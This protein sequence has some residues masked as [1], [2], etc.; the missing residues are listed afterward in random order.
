[1][2]APLL[3]AL[4]GP[5]RGWPVTGPT[6]VLRAAL[7]G[8]ALATGAGAQATPAAERALPAPG[9]A[10]WARR[11][12]PDVDRSTAWL[13]LVLDGVRAVRAHS[14]CSASA[15]AF[16]LGEHD[17]RAL[18]VLTWRWKVEWAPVIDDHRIRSGDDFALRV[19]AVFAPGHAAPPELHYV[20]TRR[21]PRGET[22]TSPGAA[23]TRVIS[24]G[25]GTLDA[26]ESVRADLAADFERAFRR[27][28]PALRAIHLL[29]DTDDSCQEAAAYVAD[30][31]LLPR[32]P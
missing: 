23:L 32:D 6:A 18:P 20:W 7:A 21:V 13:P 25:G 3:A 24:A 4:R 30:L 28:A 12:L 8:L 2:I 10:G 9:E 26:W 16:A 17:L 15:L 29:S 27:P 14:I 22:W 11:A 31:R 1:L 19:V 5:A